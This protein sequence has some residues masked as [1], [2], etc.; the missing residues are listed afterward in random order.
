MEESIETSYTELEERLR[1]ETLLSET[2]SRFINLPA[3]QIDGEI[4]RR[5]E[6]QVFFF[7][8][9]PCLC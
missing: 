6:G 7:D 2:S 1:F 3:D 9:L 4:L 8:I 5:V